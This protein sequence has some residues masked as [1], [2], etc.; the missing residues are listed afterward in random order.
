MQSSHGLPSCILPEELENQMD[1]EKVIGLTKAA[2]LEGNEC[3]S[4]LVAF[5]VYDTKPVHFLSMSCTWLKWVEKAKV[6]FGKNFMVATVLTG[7]C[8]SK[9]GGGPFGCGAF[10]C[11]L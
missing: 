11:C 1:A 2:V 6:V 8:A 10:N 9:N 7:G 4:N 3:C 5:S